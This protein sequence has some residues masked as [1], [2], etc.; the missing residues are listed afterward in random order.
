MEMH[1]THMEMDVTVT[2]PSATSMGFEPS[3]YP[4]NSS[5]V[6]SGNASPGV[7]AEDIDMRL[8]SSGLSAT[9]IPSASSS[10]TGSPHSYHDQIGSSDWNSGRGK[11]NN[12]T[13]SLHLSIVGNDYMHGPEC[14]HNYSME[15]YNS[16]EFSAQPK[17]F[18]GK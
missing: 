2:Y 11:R 18:V 13:T 15:D 3:L 16:F 6:L 4:E 17:N 12:N 14:P 10:V 5:Y 7:Y 1:A 8:P 9:S